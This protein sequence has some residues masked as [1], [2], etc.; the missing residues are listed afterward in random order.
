MWPVIL[1]MRRNEICIPH[2]EHTL[3][4]SGYEYAW[5]LFSVVSA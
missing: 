5:R 1:V 4:I 2:Y 3:I